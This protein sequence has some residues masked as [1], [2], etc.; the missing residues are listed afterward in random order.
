[1]KMSLRVVVI[2]GVVAGLVVP[3]S[4]GAFM[5]ISKQRDRLLGQADA[6]H[7]RATDILALGVQKALWD[8]APEGAVPLVQSVMQDNRIVQ[9]TVLGIPV[10]YAY[11][12]VAWA[13][14]IALMAL[15]IER[16]G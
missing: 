7:Q 5:A 4:V 11:F 9:A 3:M 16:G 10:L 2:G 1:M 6:T 12:F 14:L 15:I 13:A 8:L